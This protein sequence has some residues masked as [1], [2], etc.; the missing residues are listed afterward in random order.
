MLTKELI[1]SKKVAGVIVPTPI[2]PDNKRLLALATEFIAIYQTGIGANRETLEERLAPL[3]LSYNRTR[4]LKG[5]NQLLLE[6][7]TFAAP[8]SNLA[9]RRMAIFKAAAHALQHAASHQTLDE[10]RDAVSRSLGQEDNAVLLHCFSDLPQ[11]H[12][13]TAFQAI[14]PTELLAHYNRVLLESF[15]KFFKSR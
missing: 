6:R 10:Y 7:S 12:I 3:F 2:H 14:E 13:L 9:A 1:L 5:L 4:L 11:R 15:D 8:F